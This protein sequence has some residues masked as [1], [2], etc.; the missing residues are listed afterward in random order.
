MSREPRVPQPSTLTGTSATAPAGDGRRDE[1]V[2]DGLMTVAE[3]VAF[4]R[5]SRSTVYALMDTG[6]LAYVRIGRA[7]RIPK[8]AVVALAAAH[9]KGDFVGSTA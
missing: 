4:L 6:E 3:A 9:L 2:R 7:R 5:L 8:R 1:L